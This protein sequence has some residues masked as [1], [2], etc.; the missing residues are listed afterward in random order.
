VIAA[1]GAPADITGTSIVLVG[2]YNPMLLQPS[3]LLKTGALT[4][5]DLFELEYEL[6]APEVT[7]AKLPWVRAVVE[8]DKLVFMTTI[9]A[10][11]AE[12]IRDFLLDVVDLQPIKRFT[13]LGIN[14]DRHF[15]VSSS[16]TWHKAGH[17]LVPKKDLWNTFL[18]KAGMLGVTV[19][20]ERDD[21][22]RGSINVRV[23]SSTQIHPGVFVNINDHFDAVPETLESDPEQLL[24]H[25]TD[26]WPAAMRR[27][28][29]ILSAIRDFV[30]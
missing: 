3:K 30:G 23:E 16:E 5:A 11:A 25:L 1:A 7:V 22:A 10:P 28:D 26:G 4:D 2:V 13:A 19:R 18:K 12:P 27:A 17:R 8:R 15:G 24:V 6:I 21:G 14:S 29:Q 9:Q 20:G